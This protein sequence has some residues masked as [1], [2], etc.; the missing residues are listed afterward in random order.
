MRSLEARQRPPLPEVLRVP[1]LRNV[2]ETAPHFHDGSSPTLDDAVRMMAAAQ[3]DQTLSDQQVT[4][5]VTFP[6]TLTGTFDGA[7]VVAPPP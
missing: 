4:A 2:A 1:S 5:I 3:L 7:L 6:R